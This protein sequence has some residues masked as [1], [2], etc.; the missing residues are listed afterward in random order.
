[1]TEQDLQQQRSQKWR[2]DGERVQTIEQARH[3]IDD[4]GFCIMYPDRSLPLVPTFMGAFI[5]SAEHLPDTKHAFADPRSQQATDLMVRLLRERTAYEMSLSPATDVIISAAI[6]PFF[7]ALVGD[8]NPKAAPR[9]R[10]Q[11]ARISPLT[12]NV[13]ENLQKHGPLS[14]EKLRERVG[15]EPS[16]AALDRALGELWTVLKITRV[17]YREGE[18]AIWDVLYRWAPDAVKE[19]AGIS[20]PEA[21]SA[22][23]S[24]YLQTVVAAGQD[25]IELLFSH[26]ASRSKIRD[27]IHALLAARELSVIAIGMKTMVHLTPE[28]DVRRRV[29]G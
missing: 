16:N 2:L 28:P 27:A 8:R 25:E 22:L 6:F 14:R 23:I 24:K 29:N 9:L 15:N 26:L 10:T 4:V 12:V 17:D 11:G 13:F 5:G 21:I 20:A 19:G 7:Y 18:G 1:M 3:F